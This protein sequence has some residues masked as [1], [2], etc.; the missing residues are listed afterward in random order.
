MARHFLRTPR[1]IAAAVGVLAAAPLVLSAGAIGGTAKPI[2][3]PAYADRVTRGPDGNVWILDRKQNLVG[4]V[5]PAGPFTAFPIPTPDSQP[6]YICAGSDGNL[7]FTEAGTQK[8]GRITTA[9]VITEFKVAVSPF[10]IIDGPDGNRWFNDAVGNVSKI[11]EDGFVQV[12]HLGSNGPYHMGAFG[13]DGNLW[14][15]SSP[16]N[17]AIRMTPAGVTTVFP[18][19]APN[20][21]YYGFFLVSGPDGNL[22]ATHANNI[23]RITT[24]GV[25]TD[26][27][28]PTAN[29][30]P[31]GITVGADGNIW[32]TEYGSGNVGQLVV[33]TATASGQ[34]T[35]NEDPVGSGVATIFPLGAAWSASSA[36]SIRSAAEKGGGGSPNPCKSSFL[37]QQD[38]GLSSGNLLRYDTPPAPGCA[39]LDAKSV[40]IQCGFSRQGPL[41]CSYTVLNLGPDP[42]EKV[43]MSPRIDLNR[44]ECTSTCG[45]CDDDCEIGTLAPGGGYTVRYTFGLKPSEEVP[46]ALFFAALNVASA[47][48]DPDLTNNEDHAS[49]VIPF[50]LEIIP[51]DSIGQPTT[52]PSKRGKP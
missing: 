10:D 46:L 26:Y 51:A 23:A 24:S 16:L 38:A 45:K 1:V 12:F 11:S 36:A 19:P 7:W 33:S 49:F 20:T 29:A 41:T 2:N 31:S 18:L 47:T 13:P 8:I 25:I 44:T 43:V 27:T 15:M 39:D 35:I 21:N 48:L 22:W 4:R 17:A 28:I 37:V 40:G 5:T 3:F 42:A 30:A 50:G 6:E 14:F 9:G 32:F 52:P 34:A